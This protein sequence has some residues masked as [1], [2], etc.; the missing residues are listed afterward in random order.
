MV[1]QPALSKCF[2][3]VKN[4]GI[5]QKI[6]SQILNRSSHSSKSSSSMK[7]KSSKDSP[8][9]NGLDTDLSN[10]EAG[11]LSFENRYVT[12]ISQRASLRQTAKPAS[13]TSL[14]K[15]D[16]S[17]ELGTPNNCYSLTDSSDMHSDSVSK[18]AFQSND[19]SRPQ[20]VPR[21]P[22]L[23]KR[24]APKPPVSG[25]DT[26]S[27]SSEA[28]SIPGGHVE[29]GQQVSRISSQAIETLAQIHPENASEKDQ[30]Y[31]D[32]QPLSSIVG[33]DLSN[34]EIDDLD[35]SG[36]THS[37]TARVPT[38]PN[39]KLKSCSLSDLRNVRNK[40]SASVLPERAVSLDFKNQ[41]FPEENLC[42]NAN[43][44]MDIDDSEAMVHWETKPN[45]PTSG[46]ISTAYS[47]DILSDSCNTSNYKGRPSIDAGPESM[48][49]IPSLNSLSSASE[50]NNV[51]KSL[52]S[53]NIGAYDSPYKYK[54]ADVVFYSSTDSSF[55]GPAILEVESE[56]ITPTPSKQPSPLPPMDER[57][58]TSLPP[59]LSSVQDEKLGG[60]TDVEKFA[61][62][63]NQIVPNHKNK[64]ILGPES[65]AIKKS[66]KSV[67][68]NGSSPSRIPKLSQSN[69]PIASKSISSDRNQVQ[70]DSRRYSNSKL[71]DRID[72]DEK[73]NESSNSILMS[74]ERFLDIR[75]RFIPQSSP[76]TSNNKPKLVTNNRSNHVG[77]SIAI[78]IRPSNEPNLDFESWTYVSD[79]GNGNS[80]EKTE[81]SATEPRYKTSLQ[82]I[83]GFNGADAKTKVPE[84]AGVTLKSSTDDQ[85][86]AMNF[87]E[88]SRF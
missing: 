58:F 7:S 60:A 68:S 17:L 47:S 79:L 22:V 81:P 34:G 63:R 28:H 48:M 62:E 4:H 70:D 71:A 56:E 65:V 77:S 45:V 44:D 85:K 64:D 31:N 16:I 72:H 10:S 66:E 59:Q 87:T 23:S 38:P 27:P 39:G 19:H 14:E 83:S 6:K 33:E 69:I 21:K 37:E 26:H 57:L 3:S 24:K 1:K 36:K 88:Q 50:N 43:M 54:K 41:V 29:S 82:A 15:G 25:V 86:F 40:K 8:P 53:R 18:S 13:P 5:V 84:V 35:A 76:S 61:S 55:A 51:V 78:P 30:S 46:T 32:D 42:H 49:G 67:Q 52:N 20:P 2:S 9:R 12:N 74:R 11:S 73:H 75:N 80:F